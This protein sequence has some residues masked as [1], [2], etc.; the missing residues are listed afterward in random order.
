MLTYALTAEDNITEETNITCM[1]GS[2]A[3]TIEIYIKSKLLEI[4]IL[5][6]SINAGPSS[7][8]WAHSACKFSQDSVQLFWNP[9]VVAP[10]CYTHYKLST[11]GPSLSTTTSLSISLELGIQ[12]ITAA[13]KC[14][15]HLGDNT[16]SKQMIIDS[17]KKQQ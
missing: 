15:D 16:T 9:P 2:A 5:S 14:I 17:S 13:V 12:S 6:T 1:D 3:E 10:E 8:S 4:V 11:N 7:P